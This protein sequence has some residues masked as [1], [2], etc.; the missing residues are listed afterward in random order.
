MFIQYIDL[1]WFIYKNLDIT[2]TIFYINKLENL[3]F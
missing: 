3:M 1:Q 2:K